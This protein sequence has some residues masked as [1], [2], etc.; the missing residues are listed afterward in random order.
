MTRP[1]YAN[2]TRFRQNYVERTP[3]QAQW[4]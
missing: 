4:F 2:L 1:N 3:A